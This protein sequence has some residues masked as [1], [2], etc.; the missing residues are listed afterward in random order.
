MPTVKHLY[1]LESREYREYVWD[2]HLEGFEDNIQN[3][4]W[5]QLLQPFIA[6]K[7]FYISEKILPL[8][9]PALQELVGE[10]VTE[11]LPAL[12]CLFLEGLRASGPVIDVIRP[13]V[14]ARQ[15]STDP[16]VASYWDSEG[17]DWWEGDD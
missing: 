3:S 5:L 15:I 16:I 7:N 17:D 10:R 2:Y 6:V 8:I 9:A 11:A 12:E 13:F 14:A 1:I 4:Q